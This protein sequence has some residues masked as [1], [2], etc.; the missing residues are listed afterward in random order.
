MKIIRPHKGYR[1]IK[2]ASTYDATTLALMPPAPA[3]IDG[4][5]SA[6]LL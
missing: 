1:A 6:D 4:L 3:L 5:P 2:I